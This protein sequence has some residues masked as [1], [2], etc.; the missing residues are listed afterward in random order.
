MELL[1]RSPFDRALRTKTTTQIIEETTEGNKIINQDMGTAAEVIP[2]VKETMVRENF[3]G[4]LICNNN[5]V[6][7]PIL[8]NL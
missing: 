8:M 2:E 3:Q 1:R 6:E 4:A 7:V 5:N